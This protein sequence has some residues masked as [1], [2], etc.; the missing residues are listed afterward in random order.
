MHERVRLLGAL[1]LG[2]LLISACAAGPS[3]IPGPGEPQSPAPGAGRTMVMVHGGENTS[4]AI[5]EITAAGGT[6]AST[7]T[8][9]AKYLFN[10]NLIFLDDRGLPYPVLAESVPQFDTGDWRVFPDGK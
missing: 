3:T 4:Y 9:E 6:T 8:N 7:R 1:L 5:K 10:A 2:G